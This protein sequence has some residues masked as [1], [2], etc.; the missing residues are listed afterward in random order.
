MWSAAILAGGQARRFGGLDK[1][2]LVVEGRPILHRQIAELLT[3]TAD[4]LIVGGPARSGLPGSARVVAD[5]MPGRG[6]L[7]GLYTAL[8][9]AKGDATIVVACDMPYVAA[10]LLDYLLTL[11]HDADAVVPR[12]ERGYHPLC[13]AY[14]RACV[15]PAAA[16]LAN[17]RLKMM[18]LLDEIRV[19]VVTTEEI[20]V[21][22]D[23][24][25]L[26]ANVNTP[27]EYGGIEAE[28][29]HQL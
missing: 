13:A 8:E 10:P 25:R 18:D 9:E 3:L 14:T 12:T 17:G 26:L 6:P 29:G 19:R 15:P 2:A 11:T 22:G 4:I 27:A 23:H 21:F 24:H 5:R 16:R 1:S 7:A 20:N 28:Q